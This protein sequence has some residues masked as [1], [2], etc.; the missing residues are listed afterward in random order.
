MQLYHGPR[1]FSLPFKC[2]QIFAVSNYN[3]LFSWFFTATKRAS[4]IKHDVRRLL[5]PV[6]VI[7]HVAF[8]AYLDKIVS[9][10]GI[11]H[12]IPFDKILLNEGNAFNSHTGMFVCPLSGVYLF[13]FTIASGIHVRA[14]YTTLHP[15]FI[16]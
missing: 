1:C 15:T 7:T 16:Y 10:L 5:S 13:S 9:H 14:V 11:D 3:V 8:S 2:D 6:Q 4:I 12:L